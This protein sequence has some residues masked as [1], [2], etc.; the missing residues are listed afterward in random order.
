LVAEILKQTNNDQEAAQDIINDPELLNNVQIAMAPTKRRIPS[1]YKPTEEQIQSLLL[2]GDYPRSLVYGTLRRANG[3]MEAAADLLITG[4]GV[5]E[6][7]P[8]DGP[9]AA[10]DETAE[11]SG[12]GD[13]EGGEGG[14]GANGEGE[15]EGEGGEGG[16][17]ANGEGEGEGEGE[18]AALVPV[19]EKVLIMFS[20][21]TSFRLRNSWKER[22]Q[23]G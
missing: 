9:F 3:D 2:L 23:K 12:G 14:E 6:E 15:G 18:G 1:G 5:S 13:G 16:G 8:V 20:S 17:G 21:L 7:I 10:V 19:P 4:R 11:G 22:G